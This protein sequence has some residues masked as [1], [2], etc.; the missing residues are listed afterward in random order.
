MQHGIV[1]GDSVFTEPVRRVVKGVGRI[2]RRRPAGDDRKS[3]SMF[4]PSATMDEL[5]KFPARPSHIPPA[6]APEAAE[7]T[8]APDAEAPE[9]TEDEQTEP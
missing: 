9:A 6:E 4:S 8:E 2:F 1:E 5:P 7:G 3:D